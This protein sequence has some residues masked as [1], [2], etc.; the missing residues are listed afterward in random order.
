MEMKQRTKILFISNDG[1]R[2]GAP[3]I[4]LNLIRWLKSHHDL[5]MA[6]VLMRNGSLRTEFEQELTTYTWIP[7]D[8]NQPERIHKRLVN[9]LLQRGRTD[10]GK[11]LAQIIEKEKEM[12]E[13]LSLSD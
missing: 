2:T 3:S 13:R 10:P 1:S 5:K 7:T 11:W 8:L 9:T 4:L 12:T 6:A